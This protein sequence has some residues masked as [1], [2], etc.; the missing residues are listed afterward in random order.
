[1]AIDASSTF[2]QI[3]IFRRTDDA[4]RLGRAPASARARRLQ[5]LPPISRDS[6]QCLLLESS[7]TFVIQWDLKEIDSASQY[8]QFL[9]LH[10]L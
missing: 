4:N 7:K 8:L 5:V 2:R 3:S 10:C 1:M 9:G 6:S